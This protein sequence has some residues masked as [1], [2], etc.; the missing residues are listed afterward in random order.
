MESKEK[1]CT[2]I[3]LLHSQPYSFLIRYTLDKIAQTLNKIS[4]VRSQAC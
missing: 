2:V 3:V 4:E 1:S